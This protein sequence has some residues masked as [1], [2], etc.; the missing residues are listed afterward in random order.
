MRSRLVI[1]ELI[2][3]A[4]IGRLFHVSIKHAGC[5]LRLKEVP[6]HMIAPLSYARRVIPLRT[7]LSLHICPESILNYI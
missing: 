1:F 4:A 2:W 3:G 5:S 7:R 6:K